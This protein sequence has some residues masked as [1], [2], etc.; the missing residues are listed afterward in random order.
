M[1]LLIWLL[2]F[3]TAITNSAEAK[4]TPQ[5]IVNKVNYNY[6]KIKD[7]TADLTLQ[8]N[9]HLLGC[10][11]TKKETG[12][13]YFK[14]PNKGRATLN[15]ITHFAKGNRIRKID[16]KG[17]RYYVKLINA[18]DFAVGFTPKLISHNF[19]LKI[20]KQDKN[21]VILLGT[22]KPGV[23]K[24]VKKM[25]FHI[26]TKEYLLRQLDMVFTNK[27]LSG[28]INVEYKK[29]KGIWVPIGFYGKSAVQVA[30]GFLV[31]LDISLYGKNFKINTGI[32]NKFFEP[33]F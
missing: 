25:Y 13:G 18:P 33:G 26:D 14:Y 28:K 10:T 22:P 2:L 7:A 16:K 4:L 30:G 27:K 21:K 32:P 1:K 20:H 11:G 19:N 31:G 29:I 8:Y 12:I 3:I 23:L 15:G 5:Q 24:N 9:L 17:R 6:A